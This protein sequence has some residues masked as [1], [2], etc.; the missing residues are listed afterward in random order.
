MLFYCKNI[1]PMDFWQ[2]F[3][4]KAYGFLAGFFRKSLWI[5]GRLLKKPI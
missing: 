2:A 3:L 5:F 1:K 4:E